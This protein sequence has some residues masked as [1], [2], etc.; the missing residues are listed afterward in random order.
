[1]D[2]ASEL[3]VA[4]RALHVAS[5]GVL[6]GGALLMAALGRPRPAAGSRGDAALDAAATYEV[7]AW[8]ALALLVVS[9][10]GNLGALA[11]GVPRRGTA[12]GDLFLVKLLAVL[13]VL[14]LSAGR[15][16]LVAVLLRA[17]AA[18]ALPATGARALRRAYVATAAAVAAVL[19]LGVGLAHG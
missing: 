16:W 14:L 12:W 1:V 9:G 15:T 2:R 13:G 8:A 10:F 5:A 6:L 3:G 17:R 4:F 18:G 11:P 19:A 7:V